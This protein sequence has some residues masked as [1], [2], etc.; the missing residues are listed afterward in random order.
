MGSPCD[1]YLRCHWSVTVRMR[2]TK[3]VQTWS[4]GPGPTPPPIHIR[5]SSPSPS[6]PLPTC[7]NL[8]TWGPPD[9]FNLFHYTTH[10]S[11]G[12]WA[13]G[14]R[15]KE[16]PC[17]Y[18][19]GFLSEFSRLCKFFLQKLKTFAD[20]NSMEINQCGSVNSV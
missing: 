1:Y 15:L 7:S 9:L 8:L 14:I 11:I 10:T 17:F 3:P 16:P 5:T 6:L 18:V 20:L 13:L 2:T 19:S 4:L 12:K